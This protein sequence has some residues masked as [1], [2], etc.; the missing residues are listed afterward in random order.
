MQFS[1]RSDKG[2]RF[3]FLPTQSNEA[4][5]VIVNGI[6]YKVLGD[7]EKEAQ[8]LNFLDL[9]KES[10]TPSLT[11]EELKEKVTMKE[12]K[13]KFHEK[14]AKVLENLI[15]RFCPKEKINAPVTILDRMKEYNIPGASIAVINNG[16]M[17]WSQGF[18]NLENQSIRIQAASISKT[19]NALVVLSL[20]EDGTLKV[21]LDNGEKKVGL[22]DDIR[23]LLEKEIWDAL[24]PKHERKEPVTIRGL[25]SHTAGVR[26]GE[27]E[28]VTGFRGYFR[29]EALEEEIL[30]LEMIEEIS[31]EDKRELE[32][33]RALREMGHLPTV[34]EILMG[35]N[36]AVNSGKIRLL[37]EAEKPKLGEKGEEKIVMHYQ[38]GGPMILQKIVEN[39]CKKP[40]YEVAEE[41]IF[42]PLGMDHSS[43]SEKTGLYS[44]GYNQDG[45]MVPG[46]SFRY[47][48]SAAAGLWST[49]SDLAKI[50]IEI[51][52]VY[53]GKSSIIGQELAKEMLTYMKGLGVAV[54]PIKGNRS[55]YFFHEGANAGFRSLMIGNVKGQGAVIMTNSDNGIALRE[56]I[57][58][59]IARAYKWEDTE[60][61]DMME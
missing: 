39:V 37:P 12:G 35:E 47:P 9:K 49:P 23:D 25:L 17:K 18:G 59:S 56:E 40:F 52:K 3:G 41:K 8:A 36:P 33:L 7:S 21:K 15:Y 29:P 27:G 16:K 34:D 30:R 44:N 60:Q 10:L 2:E 55:L 19:V 6:S 32:S 43:F 26:L 42:K 50:V 13:L 45:E 58:A 38:G 57:V 1:I 31:V 11:M 51:Q 24:D 28:G 48:E 54:P 20:I 22:D 46:G 5:S 53:D 14:R 61:V 4:A